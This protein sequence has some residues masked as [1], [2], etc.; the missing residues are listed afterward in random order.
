MEDKHILNNVRILSTR[1]TWLLTV[2]VMKTYLS[3]VIIRY[4]LIGLKP[5]PT[6]CNRIN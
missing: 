6:F 3:Q 1:I 2:D 4:I 5:P